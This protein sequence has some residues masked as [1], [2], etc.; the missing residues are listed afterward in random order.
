MTEAQEKIDELKKQGKQIW[1]ISR[2]NAFNQCEY[3]YYKTYIEGDRGLGNIYS[4]L[5]S[6]SHDSLESYYNGEIDRNKI[7]SSLESGLDEA[8]MLDIKFP[9]ETIADNWKADMRHFVLNFSKLPKPL[10]TE[11]FLL[12]ELAPDLW[13]QGYVDAE[14]PDGD[15]LNIYDW[16]TSSKFD[17]DKLLDA[18][19]QLIVYK[20]GRESEG[21]K[22]GKIAWCMLKY[23]Y[24]CYNQKNGK[25][26]RVMCNRGKWV[27]EFSKQ[28]WLVKQFVD[29]GMDE[30]EYQML[31]DEAVST[32]SIENFPKEIKDLIWFE[33]AFVEY[34]ATDELIEETKSYVVNTVS[35]INSKSKIKDDWKPVEINQKNSFFCTHL[36]NHRKNCEYLKKFYDTLKEDGN[37]EDKE[38]REL[39][40]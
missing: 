31:I 2:L 9:N 39:F 37:E 26:K 33:D 16:K 19:R 29:I 11:E 7:V 3:G 40:G 25:P 23:L 18:G 34:E 6:V 28:T 1:S 13:V 10:N 32:N 17:K 21:K 36:C 30:F 15:V 8:D 22:V 14:E 24:V 4:H 5:G 27:K 12:F 20:I 35:R 38:M